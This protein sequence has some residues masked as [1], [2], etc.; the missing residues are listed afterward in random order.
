MSAVMTVFAH[1]DHVSG[2]WTATSEDIPGLVVEAA[3][4]DE[5]DQ[6][7][8]ELA[9][10]LLDMNGASDYVSPVVIQASTSFMLGTTPIQ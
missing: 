4:F 6:S 8:Q 10:L 9:P 3:T 1:K 5:L 2:R 7:V